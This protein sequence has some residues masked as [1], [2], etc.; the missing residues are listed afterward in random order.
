M[1]KNLKE[2][3]NIMRRESKI[4]EK[5]LSGENFEVKMILFKMKNY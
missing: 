5:G 4:E 2:S 1:F 3:I